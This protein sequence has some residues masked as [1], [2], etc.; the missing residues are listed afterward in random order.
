MIT[1]GETPLTLRGDDGAPSIALPAPI[2]LRPAIRAGRPARRATCRVARAVVLRTPACAAALPPSGA[3]GH[4]YNEY[5][6]PR[7]SVTA[8]VD[9][10][11][12]E[13]AGQ[14]YSGTRHFRCRSV[15]PLVTPVRADLLLPSRRWPPPH[16]SV[17]AA[18]IRLGLKVT[19]RGPSP[20]AFKAFRTWPDCALARSCRRL[21][22]FFLGRR[23]HADCA[24][25]IR[26]Y[27]DHATI[28]G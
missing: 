26:G 13:V 14:R 2:S 4:L 8:A 9:L 5:S 20:V 7:C 3:C 24:A 10:F 11:L 15:R 1:A 19:N 22:Y 23:H 28:Y 16:R 21:Y 12:V 27:G 17:G 18:N 25:H 6:P